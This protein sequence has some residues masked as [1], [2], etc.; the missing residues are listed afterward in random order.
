MATLAVVP[1]ARGL[2]WQDRGP[3][4]FARLGDRVSRF[5]GQSG[6]T[7]TLVQH[8]EG[9]Q[10]AHYYRNTDDLPRSHSLARQ[11]ERPDNGESRLSH[12]RDPDRPDLDRL[13]RE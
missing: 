4:R 13:L 10:T 7:V 1:R 2:N 11:Q 5:R 9:Q 3:S 12:L 6:P 8:Q